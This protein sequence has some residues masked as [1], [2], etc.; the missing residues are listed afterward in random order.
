MELSFTVLFDDFTYYVVEIDIL[1]YALKKKLIGLYGEKICLCYPNDQT[2]SQLIFSRTI[3]TSS[4]VESIQSHD[5][6]GMCAD[7]FQEEFKQ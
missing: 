1:I 7:I 2:K 6:F 5:A 4:L 3:E